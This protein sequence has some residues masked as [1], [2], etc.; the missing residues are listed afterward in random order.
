MAEE[1]WTDHVREMYGFLLL[2]KAKSWM[3]VY[4]SNV[5]GSEKTRYM[6]Y[7]GGSPRYRRRLTEEAEAG[8]PN[9]MMSKP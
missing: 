9:L 8:Y 1:A 4:N 7:T 3:T 6:I 2:R 5:E